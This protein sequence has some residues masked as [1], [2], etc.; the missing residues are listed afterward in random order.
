M[1][2]ELAAP[3]AE[4]IADGA[5]KT[6]QKAARALRHPPCTSRPRI[7]DPRSLARRTTLSY[8]MNLGGDGRHPNR[9]ASPG[10]LAARS[11]FCTVCTPTPR[12]ADC[13]P[14]IS[15]QG[16]G[17]GGAAAAGTALVGDPETVAQRDAMN[18]ADLWHRHFSIRSAIPHLEKPTV[19]RDCFSPRHF[20][21]ARNAQ[22]AAGLYPRGHYGRPAA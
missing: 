14:R 16:V 17:S 15:G 3:V 11:R 6:A 7:P 4:Q 18:T 9:L 8:A 19:F 12:L 22:P 1:W 21:S 5:A 10:L 20:H 2:G 13:Q